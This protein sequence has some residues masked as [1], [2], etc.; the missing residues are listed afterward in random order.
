MTTNNIRENPALLKVI[1]VGLPRTGT[2]TLHAALEILGFGPCHHPLNLGV[3]YYSGKLARVIRGDASAKLL[4]DVFRGYGS[5][6]DTTAGSVAEPLYRAYPDAKFILT[7]MTIRDVNK[8]IKSMEK[9]SFKFFNECDER[10]A[11]VLSGTASEE[12]RK[13]YEKMK[14][15][16]G[17]DWNKAYLEVYHKGQLMTDPEGEFERHKQFIT[18]LIPPEQLLIFDVLEGWGPLVKFLGVPDPNEPFPSSNDPV[19]YK[20][21]ELAWQQKLIQS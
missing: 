7:R 13:I 1:G 4:D 16:G 11:R 9:T 10:E 12:D 15:F 19:G 21:R 3:D 2:Y 18:Q 6:V 5:A 20:Q 14:E 8:W 17:L